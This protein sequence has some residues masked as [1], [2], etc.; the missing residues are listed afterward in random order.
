MHYSHRVRLHSSSLFHTFLTKH[1][2][3][4]VRSTKLSTP[5]RQPHRTIT[6]IERFAT[7][8]IWEFPFK[9]RV[10]QKSH[11]Q[12]ALYHEISPE[13]FRLPKRKLISDNPDNSK[14]MFGSFPFYQ[15]SCILN[16][17]IISYIIVWYYIYIRVCLKIGYPL[18]HWWIIIIPI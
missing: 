16:I 6:S 9:P 10:A 18:S 4:S 2:K 15:P 5:P 13:L 8:V 11:G 3:H 12:T 14:D 17:F 1:A 7:P